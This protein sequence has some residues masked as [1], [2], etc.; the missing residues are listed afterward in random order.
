[1]PTI[2]AGRAHEQHGFS[3]AQA[4]ED[5]IDF[6]AINFTPLI[7]SLKVEDLSYKYKNPSY[8]I[9]VCDRTSKWYKDFDLG[10]KKSFNKTLNLL[11]TFS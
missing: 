8:T 4:D 5:F 6:F 10:L 1:M 9:S 7:F 3:H 2:R 11:I